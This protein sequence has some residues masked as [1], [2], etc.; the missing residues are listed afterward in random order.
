M[1]TARFWRVVGVDAY[2]GGDLELSELQLHGAG[3]RVD[4]TATLT[5]SHAPIA[6]ALADL[7]DGNTA[8][9]A[10]FSADHVRSAGFFIAW[11]LGSSVA[12]IG[13]RVGSAVD[14]SRF[15]SALT[16][17]Y[18]DGALWQSLASFGR[19]PWPGASA[20][21]E[22]P[23]AGG[24]NIPE[25]TLFLDGSVDFADTSPVGRTMTPQGG[26]S[27]STAQ[28]LY[29]GK[30]MMFNGS[31]GYLAS[32]ASASLGFAPGDDFTISFNAWKSTDGSA[33]YDGVV[34]TTTNASATN[35]WFVELST[36]RGFTFAAQSA[37]IF[38]VALNP[39]TSQWE[40][41][42]I[43]RKSGVL[44]AFRN[45][46]K[47]YETPDTRAYAQAGLSI[48][49]A[50]PGGYHF[51]GFL[52]QV[53]IVKGLALHDSDFVPASLVGGAS[54]AFL[55]KPVKTA[56]VRGLVGASAAISPY[57]TERL[58]AAVARDVEFGGLGRVYGTVKEK[59]TPA[60]TPL[61]RRVYL[62]DQRSR[63]VVRETWSDAVT[64]EFE[65]RFVKE[66]IKWFV[67]S[68]DHEGHYAPT[69]ADNQEAERMVLP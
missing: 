34:S 22:V 66:G 24:I 25:A 51:A 9:V 14:Q 16:L 59:N 20:L 3:G 26:V 32:P 58:A 28:A 68:L 38:S 17:Q 57:S 53:L 21:G 47:I 54:Q 60:N 11:D 56:H 18:F 62:M 43:S 55:P 4:T 27:I 45:G 23:A 30:S 37:A 7:V 1:T 49:A 12:A 35:G 40:H 44:R 33:S 64:G 15:V 39:N 19:Y 10:R 41:W 36:S 63:L 6:G 29:G 50:Y 42:E 8:T 2:S 61:R 48:G 65:F 69:S 46:A 13:L 5:S 67:Y 31:N 52:Q